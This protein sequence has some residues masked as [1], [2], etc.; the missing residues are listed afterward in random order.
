MSNNDRFLWKISGEQGEG[1]D[2]TGHIFAYNAFKNGFYISSYRKYSSR[3]KGGNTT[4]EVLF[5]NQ[6]VYA[7]SKK[8]NVLIALNEKSILISR[9]Q[10]NENTFIIYDD[11]TNIENID[12]VKAIKVALPLAKI[13]REITGNALSK[14]MVAL[15]A[16][17]GVF[18][19]LSYDYI[20]KQIEKRFAKKSTTIVENN[21]K[22][23]LEGYNLVKNYLNQNNL[24]EI[25]V[26]LGNNKKMSLLTGNEALTLGMLYSGVKYFAGYPITPA[27]GILEMMI[28]NIKDF[29]GVAIQT[30]DEISAINSVIG[31]S[32]AGVRAATATSGP[33]FSLMI[34]AIGYAYMTETPVVIID[35]MR[36]GPSTGLPTKTEDSDILNVVFSGHG[37]IEKIVL[38]PSNPYEMFIFANTAFNL[39]EKY[40]LPVIILSDLNLGE[41]VY[42]TNYIDL[43]KIDIKIDRGK[44]INNITKNQ[45]LNNLNGQ[46]NRYAITDDG[47]S[48][49]IIPGTSGFAYQISG[50]EHDEEGFITENKDIRHNMMLKRKRK[51]QNFNEYYLDY[52][53]IGD[54]PKFAFISYGFNFYYLL[55]VLKE[56]YRKTNI[57]T[58]LIKIITIYPFPINQ[59]EKLLND[60]DKVI[61]FEQNMLGQLRR[62]Y[63]MFNGSKESLLI[64]KFDGDP[65]YFEDLYE[66]VYQTV[67]NKVKTY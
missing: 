21:K 13:S 46:L 49:R 45:F 35:V 34:E 37:D 36:G 5:S 9:E 62:L 19:N 42:T 6:E 26:P 20:F 27:S 33:G 2:S 25:V 11:A 48:Y 8:L 60:T 28:K 54:N 12:N 57:S 55:D 61:F 18:K 52:I 47:I 59:I 7:R 31:A 38:F 10:I 50:N 64:N 58:R 39:A 22:A 29:G 24:Q 51:L 30:E 56:L 14:N 3:I 40:Q 15:G 66:Q 43:D 1:I 4:F 41:N 63:Y 16:S 44:Y 67:F 65:F 32:I 53:D 17:L 23:F